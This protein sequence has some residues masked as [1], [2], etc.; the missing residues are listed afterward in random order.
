MVLVDLLN[1][2]SVSLRVYFWI[3]G[4]KHSRLKVRSSIIRMAKQAIQNSGI[5]IPDEGREIV[6]SQAIPIRLIRDALPREGNETEAIG[7]SPR[8]SRPTST[9]DEPV[10]HSAEGGFE[11]EVTVM[12]EQAK[13][14]RNPE[15]GTNLLAVTEADSA[16]PVPNNPGGKSGNSEEG[17]IRGS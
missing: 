7:S 8:T 1:V 10:T 15:L 9:L 4:I 16:K 3:D 13:K 14:A 11:S 2:S 17:L 5:T 12:E 6:V